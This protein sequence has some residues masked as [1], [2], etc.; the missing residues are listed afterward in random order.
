MIE[1]SIASEPGEGTRLDAVPEEVVLNYTQAIEVPLSS[2][3][4][5]GPSGEV[6]LGPLQTNE[7]R[8]ILR[9][10][11]EGEMQA[12]GW[13]S[14]RAKLDDRV[15]VSCTVSEAR[16]ASLRFAQEV[17]LAEG[18]AVC[19][20]A[21]VTLGEIADALVERYGRASVERVVSGP[22]LIDVYL[23][24]G[25][26]TELAPARAGELWSAAI[27]G[28]DP[29]AAHAL[30]ILVR[31]FGAAAGD[32]SL[33]HGA[34]GVAITGGLANRIAHLLRSPAFEARFTAKG[35]YRDRMQ[36]VPVVLATYA[37][38]GLLGAAI[39]FERETEGG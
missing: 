27:D 26:E 16:A 35:R 3:V 38:P 1:L 20:R 24:L 19:V 7:S 37:E 34:M 9:A 13:L 21:E 31:C 39:A 25:G 36:R 11:I 6:A 2:V 10:P 23:H 12:G 4:L 33:A 29:L 15:R 22:G 32:I 5:L 17:V 8:T 18:G 30:D 28:S 14:T